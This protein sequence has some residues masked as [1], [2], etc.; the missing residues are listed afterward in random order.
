[1]EMIRVKRMGTGEVL[2]IPTDKIGL[3]KERDKGRKLEITILGI[4]RPDCY[5]TVDT[6]RNT[7]KSLNISDLYVKTSDD[8]VITSE[9]SITTNSEV[10]LSKND[11]IPDEVEI[12]KELSSK[13]FSP[14]K[15]GKVGKF[16]S[17]LATVQNEDSKQDVHTSSVLKNEET[18][19]D[20]K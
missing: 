12:E 17:K 9:Q 18:N 7:L 1:M 2:Y 13:G 4:E 6:S 14:G 3:I 19:N 15:L 16:G 11:I 10:V 5:V 20:G 8:T